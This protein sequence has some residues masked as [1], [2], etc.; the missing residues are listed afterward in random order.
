MIQLLLG[1][2]HRDLSPENI[3]FSEDFQTIVIDLGGIPLWSITLLCLLA[4]VTHTQLSNSRHV[5]TGSI[6]I[7]GWI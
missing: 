2:C 5:S 3:M 7:I 4:I 1:L 6:H